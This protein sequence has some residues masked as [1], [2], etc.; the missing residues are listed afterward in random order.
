MSSSS[1]G[2]AP[3]MICSFNYESIFVNASGEFVGVVLTALIIDSWGRTRTQAALCSLGGLAVLMMGLQ[4]PTVT[5]LPYMS[6]VGTPLIPYL[7]EPYHTPSSLSYLLTHSIINQ[8]SHTLH[9]QTSYQHHPSDT[10]SDLI[11]P[12][13]TAGRHGLVVRYMGRHT[14][15]V[16][17]R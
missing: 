16:S 2:D 4:W 7:G 15:A 17:H 10:P 1:G 11:V 12:G 5:Y 9:Q 14:G 3:A 8:S 13:G 6:M